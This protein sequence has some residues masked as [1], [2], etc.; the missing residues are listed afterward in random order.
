MQIELIV[1]SSVKA[2]SSFAGS[3]KLN[4]AATSCSNETMATN[5]KQCPGRQR[6]TATVFPSRRALSINI[7]V[8][9]SDETETYVK[10]VVASTYS[11]V[12]RSF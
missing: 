9:T 7:L 12:A 6:G 5:S 8:E 10:T 1:W 3:N 11:E 4:G 2:G